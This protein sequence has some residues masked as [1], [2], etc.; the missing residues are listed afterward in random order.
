[1]DKSESKRTDINY[2]IK[3]AYNIY[4]TKSDKCQKTR[5]VIIRELLNNINLVKYDR[6]SDFLDTIINELM[7]AELSFLSKTDRVCSFIRSSEDVPKTK[8][9]Q[10][11]TI[12]NKELS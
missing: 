9:E 8:L 2:R 5:P 12:A 6:T 4:Y 3:K 7:N 1:M 11:K 10:F